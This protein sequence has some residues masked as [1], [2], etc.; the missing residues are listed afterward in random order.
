MS[1]QKDTRNGVAIL[2]MDN[3]PEN[4]FTMEM[5]QHFNEALDPIETDDT[6]RGVVVT[7]AGGQFFSSGMDLQYVMVLETDAI[8]DFFKKLFTFFHRAFVF[9]KPMVA[10]INGHVV[11]SALAFSMCFDYRVM[12]KE[13][14]VC[15]FPEIDVSIIPPSGCMAMVKY[16]IGERMTDLAFL[17]GRKFDG[18]AAL[19]AGMVD[20]LAESQVVIDRAVAVA[21]E[22]GAKKPR[23]F[24]EYKKRFRGEI[25]D[26]M[27]A[28][29]LRYIDEEMDVTMF[30]NCD[31]A[32][33]RSLG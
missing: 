28:E 10:A 16:V 14:A 29:D 20:E 7:G 8:K 9:Q 32:C 15:T 12:Q 11:A 2:T 21:A 19:A 27:L 25:A 5:I 1:I 13:K 31:L 24:A 3:S 6:V 22:L 30:Q 4:A 26:R 33:L 23:L 18:S 17:S